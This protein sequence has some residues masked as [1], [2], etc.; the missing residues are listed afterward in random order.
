VGSA[1]LVV[2]VEHDAGR[3]EW[4][5]GPVHDAASCDGSAIKGADR[6]GP[7][8]RRPGCAGEADPA[9][10]RGPVV[11]ARV[12]APHGCLRRDG[13]PVELTRW[14]AVVYRFRRVR[15]MV[16]SASEPGA[17]RGVARNRGR[18]RAAAAWMASYLGRVQPPLY[19]LSALTVRRRVIVVACYPHALVERMDSA[20]RLLRIHPDQEGETRDD[21]DN[22]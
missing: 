4:S 6:G 7:P 20:E 8:R 22:G 9:D 3:A 11:S 12:P 14:A 19:G 17:G 16:G 10:S 18:D 5:G 15:E 21:T 2:G 1:D 13:D